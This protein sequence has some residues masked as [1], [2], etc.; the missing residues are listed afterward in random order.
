MPVLDAKVAATADALS[1]KLV[2]LL[3]A[4]D[5]MRSAA[6]N[7]TASAMHSVSE[8]DVR[9][10]LR[11]RR[12]RA[13]FFKADLFADPAWDMLLALYAAELGQ[14]RVTVSSLCRAAA[15][16]P[17]TALRWISTLVAQRLV[18]RSADP[19]DGRRVFVAMS[20]KARIAMTGYFGSN[21]AVHH[22]H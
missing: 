6:T 8:A 12:N 14:R 4:V 16:P 17:T 2:A 5:S 21:P 3:S 9:L 15:V 7:V 18:V 1:D 20:D 11:A 13:T 10:V 22:L 19:F